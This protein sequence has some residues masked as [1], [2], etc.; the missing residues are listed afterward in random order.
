M[1]GEHPFYDQDLVKPG[2]SGGLM[3][4]CLCAEGTPSY[5]HMHV[6]FDVSENTP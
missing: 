4:Y 1:G 6:L 5:S 3:D 2:E